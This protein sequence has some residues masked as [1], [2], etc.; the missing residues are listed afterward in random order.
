MKNEL[1]VVQ[2]VGFSE[3]ARDAVAPLLGNWSQS[4]LLRALHT[5]HNLLRRHRSLDLEGLFQELAGR[6]QAAF[7][8][9]RLPSQFTESHLRRLTAPEVRGRLASALQCNDIDV[10]ATLLD[11]DPLRAALASIDAPPGGP[12]TFDAEELLLLVMARLP[13]LRIHYG[14]D[15]SD[16]GAFLEERRWL[17]EIAVRQLQAEAHRNDWAK[18]ALP[19]SILAGII[20][21]VGGPT[22]Q[23]GSARFDALALI[24][25]RRRVAALAEE[26]RDE[27]LRY[28]EEAVQLAPDLGSISRLPAWIELYER[29]AVAVGLL[30]LFTGARSV[31][32]LL[33]EGKPRDLGEQGDPVRDDGLLI[34]DEHRYGLKPRI[35]F[36]VQCMVQGEAH[37]KAILRCEALPRRNY[38]QVKD[39][40]QRLRGGDLAS[41]GGTLGERLLNTQVA[42]RH[43]ID[44]YLRLAVERHIG[45]VVQTLVLTGQQQPIQTQVAWREQLQ[46]RLPFQA[47]PSTYDIRFPD[48]ETVVTDLRDSINGRFEERRL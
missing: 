23:W 3:R 27:A 4:D 42:L 13:S 26:L 2:L 10:I 5:P 11:P 32:S 19:T 34:A 28:A 36:V 1:Y 33:A 18:D 47:S 25:L 14:L 46:S 17:S 31:A 43:G 24:E 41:Q 16:W 7:T 40:V 29:N 22:F 44:G 20:E 48:R 12:A 21:G 30:R 38:P 9:P 6:I 45:E 8:P 15:S 35:S 39:T 37:P